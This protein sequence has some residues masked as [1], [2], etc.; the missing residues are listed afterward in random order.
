[1]SPP[2]VYQPVLLR[3]LHS[4]NTLLI[5][6]SMLTGFWV[7]NTY[8]GRFGKFPWPKMEGIIDIHGSFGLFF[9]FVL[10]FF[11][12]YSF[13]MG[14]KRLI[15]A[16]SFTQLALVRRPVW[17]LGL[18]RITNT[19]ILLAASFSLLTGR[20]MKEDWLPDGDLMQT[21]YL[22]HLTG[23]A[24]LMVCLFIH[25][26]T[27]FKVGGIPLLLSMSSLKSNPE[28]NLRES[29][30]KMI[31]GYNH[32]ANASPG[33]KL[34]SIKLVEFIVFASILAAIFLPL[35]Q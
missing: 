24:V 18:Q 9:L 25:L 10:P 7:Y 3:L 5:L 30:K 11:A 31:G 28:D 27:H 19:G 1:M 21:W 26:L 20:M 16:N 35:I 17:W 6:S 22:L 12:L 23:W 4:L 14:Q 29:F 15:Q 8:D 32:S 2:S 34:S 33:R 13:Q